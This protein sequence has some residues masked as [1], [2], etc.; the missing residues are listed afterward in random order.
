MKFFERKIS[1]GLYVIERNLNKIFLNQ[2]IIETKNIQKLK[3]NN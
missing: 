1:F 3:V 2:S